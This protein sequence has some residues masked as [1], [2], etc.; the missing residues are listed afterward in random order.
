MAVLTEWITNIILLIL[1][2]TIVELLLPNSSMQRYVKMVVGLLLLVML[3]NP[4]LSV[5]SKDV[6]ELIPLLNEHQTSESSLQ[7]SI[8]LKKIE[9]EMGQRA[10]ISEQVAV[11]MKRQVEEELIERFDVKAKDITLEIDEVSG[12]S[13]EVDV[14]EVSIHL[15]KETEELANEDTIETVAVVRID[16]NERSSDDKEDTP[17]VNEILSFLSTEWQIPK[18]IITVFWEGGEQ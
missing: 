13:D 17:D 1:L 9:I 18:D 15:A 4:I 2:A 8:E 7:N 10:Y 12:H 11:Q 16:I 6:N 5:F 3:L 14:K